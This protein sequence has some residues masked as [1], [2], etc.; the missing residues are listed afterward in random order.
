M[1]FRHAFSVSGSPSKGAPLT[2]EQEAILDK[3]ARKVVHWKMTVPAIMFLE[4]SKPLSF[5][6]SQTMVFFE[7]VIQ[8]IF[9]FKDYD[10]V[11]KLLEE[12]GN[13]ER[14]LLKIEQFDAEALQAEKAGKSP[15]SAAKITFRQRVGRVFKRTTSP[16]P[17]R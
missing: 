3:I 7:P 15:K 13:V 10:T 2:P 4:T 6:G 17:H 14:L 1:D 12:R 5:L 8:S 11:R 9:S 16:P